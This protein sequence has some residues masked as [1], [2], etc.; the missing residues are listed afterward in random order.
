MEICDQ[1]PETII[2][3]A[4]AAVEDAVRQLE[5]PCAAAVVFDCAARSAWF[6]GALAGRELEALVAAF[7]SPS[8]SLAGV[9]TRGEIGRARG[10]KGDRNHSVVVVALSAPD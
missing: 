1:T 3:S 10:A 9:C 7:G 5:A 8:P 2:E 6:R 4:G